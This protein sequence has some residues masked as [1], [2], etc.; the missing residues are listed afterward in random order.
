MAAVS[1]ASYASGGVAP[2]EIVTIFGNN[3][4]PETPVMLQLDGLGKVRTELAGTRI[5]FDGVAAPLVT[6]QARQSS[7][8]VPY[9]VAGRTSTV[10]R[11]E[12]QGPQ[13]PGLLI[14]VVASAPG[15]FT[16]DMSGR[17]Q[18]AILNE[19]G[20]TLNSRENPA[21]RGSIVVLYATGGGQTVP[22]GQDG[23]VPVSVLPKPE[24]PVYVTIGGASADVLYAGAAPYFV[25][26]AL[27]INV[28][29]PRNIDPGD[30]VPVVL[31]IGR[32]PSLPAV[33]LAVR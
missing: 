33:T 5:L 28:R 14:P 10:M 9:S 25:S 26:G 31:T 3:L 16:A 4:G 8:V 15:V 13:S 29:V 23:T 32:N 2:G 11:V 24:L 18:G 30:H 17:G 1:A 19:D 20:V 12:R 6:V 22:S 7:A 21:P 27:Q